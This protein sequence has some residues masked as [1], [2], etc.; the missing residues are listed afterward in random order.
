MLDDQE[1]SKDQKIYDIY[2]QAME[3]LNLNQRLRIAYVLSFQLEK[4]HKDKLPKEFKL[5]EKQEWILRKLKDIELNRIIELR[6]RVTDTQEGYK[7]FDKIVN[8]N[9]NDVWNYDEKTEKQI[10]E[11]ENDLLYFFARIVTTLDISMDLD[12]LIG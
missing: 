5:E 3:A 12:E 10:I 7:Y 1:A 2:K 6:H 9:P 11:I 8:D 4:K